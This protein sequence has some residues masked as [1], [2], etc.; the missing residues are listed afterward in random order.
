MLY[1]LSY[2]P[3]AAVLI[4]Q[5]SPV[6]AIQRLAAQAAARLRLSE[7]INFAA[8]PDTGLEKI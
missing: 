8:A 2:T 5:P 7:S 3:S 4:T 6:Q 1:Q